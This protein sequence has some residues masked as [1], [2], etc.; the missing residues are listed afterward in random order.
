[1]L[2]QEKKFVRAKGHTFHL[3]F[4]VVFVAFIALFSVQPAS[5][6]EVVLTNDIV[7]FE[8]NQPYMGLAAM[9]DLA[10]GVNHIQ[11]VDGKHQLW[12]LNF[13]HGTQQRSLSNTK[14][15]CTSYSIE[16]DPDGTKRAIFEW[17][18]MEWVRERKAVTVRVTV[19][20]PPNSGVASWRI[21]VDNNSEVWGL[22]EVD[23]PKFN[24]Y[25]KSGEYDIAFPERNWGMLFRKCTEELSGK[26]PTGGS[27]PMQFFCAMKDKSA[28]YMAA[29]D[30]R[31]WNKVFTVNPGKEFYVRT[32]VENMAVPGSD[33]KDPFPVMVGIY[34]GSWMEGCKI[35]RKF[36]ITAPWTSEG[37][38]SQRSSMPQA[39]KDVGLWMFVGGVQ[40]NTEGGTSEPE[41]ILIDAGK[42][43]DVPLGSHWYNW[44]VIGF[45]NN[46]PHYFPA[47]TGVAEQARD[48]VAKGQ[49]VMPYINGRIVDTANDDFDV[50]RPYCTKD[51][52]GEL[53]FETYAADSGRL[54][55]MCTYT[56]FWQDKITEI[57]ERIGVE[58][59]ANAVY[60]DQIS[61]ADPRLC[62]DKSHG[63]PLG[64]GGWWVDGYKEM[65]KKIQKV[66]HSN[67]RNMIITS[68]HAAEPFMEG[69]DAFLIWIMR[70]D[71]DIPM[72]P[73]VYSGYSIYF[74]SPA[75]F[76]NDRAWIMVQ[77]R[78]FTW[79]TQNGWMSPGELLAPSHQKKAEYLKKIGKYRVATKKYLTYGELV[80]LVEPTNEIETVIEHWPDD[81]RGH[82]PNLRNGTL[83]SLQGA[84]WKAEDN[85]IGV[86]LV[87][88]L[89]EDNTIE[90]TIDPSAYGLR[91][92]SA[93]FTI[94][95]ICP[96]GNQPPAFL[97]KQEGVPSGIIKRTETLG[98]WEIRVLE[99]SEGR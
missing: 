6:E 94:A 2:L 19:E 29:H 4:S 32:Y 10:A 83:P 61:A 42:Y 92:G 12:E 46:Y 78:D 3:C 28:V 74:A 98:P 69:V 87:N 79:G 70:D 30:S 80:D 22:W 40:A 15:A 63:H 13:G 43:F 76:H 8:F 47:R 52:L 77:G 48:L 89:E 39:L 84:V 25:L 71:R 58:L 37:R 44:H 1:M 21:W 9:V 49:I 55:S 66:A 16:T 45:D 65:L 82:S 11:P 72:L 96:E 7:R 68:E 33:H 17:R 95:R 62:F 23:F 20:L 67:G 27:M 86:F 75:S 14:A 18:D 60:I 35:Y 38:I 50:Y 26:Y 97:R 54:A 73:A 59:G 93:G 56:K 91:S 88:Y 90:F 81:S 36:A 57:V 24:G 64:G 31:A 99:I 85:S 53:H 41:R 5:A 34:R 51:Q